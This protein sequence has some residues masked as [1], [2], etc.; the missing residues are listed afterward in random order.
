[1]HAAL[2]S[3]AHKV[4]IFVVGIDARLARCIER[5]QDDACSRHVEIVPAK[6]HTFNV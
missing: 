6:D 4:N 5:A 1:M 3:V 2:D